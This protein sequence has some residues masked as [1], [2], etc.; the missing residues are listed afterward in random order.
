MKYKVGQK[1][2]DKRDLIRGR[3]I[4]CFEQEDAKYWIAYSNGIKTYLESELELTPEA[5]IS[6]FLFRLW[7]YIRQDWCAALIIFGLGV[8]GGIIL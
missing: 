3:I 8:L 6:R 5:R 1:V 4:D 2:Q 7:R